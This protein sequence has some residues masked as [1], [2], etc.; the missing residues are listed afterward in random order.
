MQIL[1]YFTLFFYEIMTNSI[2][3]T[4]CVGPVFDSGQFMNNFKERFLA[5]VAAKGIAE[6][7][8]MEDII[9]ESVYRH[10]VREQTTNNDANLKLFR[11]LHQHGDLSTIQS[12]CD[13][14]IQE[15]GYPKMNTLGKAMSEH[16]SLPPS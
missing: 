14:M 6:K 15:R 5:V 10:I 9:P 8:N 13:I 1:K 2:H 16:T 11:H 4:T 3:F 7:L 12:L